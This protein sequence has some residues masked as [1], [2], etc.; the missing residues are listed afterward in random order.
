MTTIHIYDPKQAGAALPELPPLPIGAPRG[1]HRRSCS[2][3]QPICPS[4]HQHLSV[5]HPAFTCCSLGTG[6][7]PGPHPVGAR[8][9]S[10]MT[11]KPGTGTHDT[12]TW[13]RTDFS[14]YGIAVSAFA[15]IPAAPASI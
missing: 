7:R 8:F 2:S 11:V 9:G 10:A 6:Q 3:R 14:Y 1:R 12:G 5:R 13:Y 15:Y 4:T